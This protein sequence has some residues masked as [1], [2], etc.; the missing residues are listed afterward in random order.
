M[1]L[2]KKV[3]PNQ[4]CKSLAWK[5]RKFI[6]ML[7]TFT[8]LPSAFIAF[9]TSVRANQ[10]NAYLP[11]SRD[12]YKRGLEV[13]NKIAGAGTDDS[14]FISLRV[15][16]PDLVRFYIEQSYG[17]I[18][19]RPGLDLKYR[20]IANVATLTVL[21]NAQTQLKHH[22]N[23]MFNVGCTPQEVLETILHVIIYRGFPATQNGI[24]VVREVFRERNIVTNI[25]VAQTEQDESRYQRGIKNLEEI[26]GENSTQI[27]EQ[28]TDIAPDLAHYI[29]EFAYGDIWSR[30]G[31]GHKS[32]AI[33]SVAALTAIG[34][35]Q[36][37]LKFHIK[38][39]LNVGCTQQEI[40]ELLMQ[41]S[42]YVGWSAA[43]TSTNIAQ[44]VFQEYYQQQQNYV[45]SNFAVTKYT[46]ETSQVRYE[47]GLDTLGRVTKASGEAVVRSFNDILPQLGRYI[48]EFA[49]GDII[50]RPK[51]DLRTRQLATVAAL[52]AI[53][54]TAVQGPLKVHINGA[55]NVGAN[56]QEIIE[57]ILH[58]LPFAG[59]PVVQN[60]INTAKEVFKERNLTV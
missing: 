49:Y 26:V 35:Q 6:E 43:I 48:V 17:D 12:R 59:F 56:T 28:F 13:L 24:N 8:A 58:M 25:D 38:V 37:L 30:P 19:S 32:R 31:L 5:R 23:G 42:V 57:A 15:F 29:I 21:G 36:S 2:Y 60:A 53:G 55:L 9:T 14:T 10:S 45:E 47:R 3:I 18:F 52:T 41:M 4:T 22:I 16:S 40:V 39:A 33:A 11:H 27:A 7:A 44:E 51:L 54:T 1:K 20:E 50:S 34:N 46:T